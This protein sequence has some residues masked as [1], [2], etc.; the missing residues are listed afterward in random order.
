MPEAELLDELPS[1]VRGV[2]V[3]NELLDNLPAAVVE[4]TDDGWMERVVVEDGKGLG[5]GSRFPAADA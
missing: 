2:I 1:T 4:K 5:W 3:A